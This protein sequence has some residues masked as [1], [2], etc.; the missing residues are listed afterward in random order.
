MILTGAYTVLRV[1]SLKSAALKMSVA[2]FKKKAAEQEEKVI[3]DITAKR[4]KRCC[5][6]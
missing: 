2:K 5:K 6:F 3:A 4:D 1:Q